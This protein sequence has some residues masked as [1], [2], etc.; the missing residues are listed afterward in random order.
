MDELNRSATVDGWLSARRELSSAL[1]RATGVLG[2]WGVAGLTGDALQDQNEQVAWLRLEAI[3]AGVS[4]IWMVGGEPRHPSRWH[5]FVS[6]KYGRTK[7]GSFEERL[8]Q[9]LK[10][11]QIS[12]LCTK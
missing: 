2:G 7:G 8:D 11:V 4:T 10:S 5:Q 9:V 1:G 6:D 12:T 3:Q